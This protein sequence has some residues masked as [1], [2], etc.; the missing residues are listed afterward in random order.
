[1]L[2]WDYVPGLENGLVLE[3]WMVV[4]LGALGAWKPTRL[5]LCLLQ[6]GSIFTLFFSAVVYTVLK[7]PWQAG[8]DHFFFTFMTALEA[9]AVLM[10]FISLAK[11]K[12]DAAEGIAEACLGIVA[13]A[14]ILKTLLDLIVFF[15]ELWAAKRKGKVRWGPPPTT[16]IK[17]P[18][19][20]TT[21]GIGYESVK[22]AQPA[23]SV[24]HS[25]LR[26]NTTGS[27]RPSDVKLARFQTQQQASNSYFPFQQPTS[28]V[29]QSRTRSEG[30]EATSLRSFSS[31]TLS[32]SFDSRRSKLLGPKA[33]E[34]QAEQQKIALI[35]DVRDS[36]L[37]VR[38]KS[39]RRA[40]ELTLL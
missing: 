32:S 39:R 37:H 35:C 25:I 23:A 40:S 19:E 11:H 24:S 2:F 20:M 8:V 15:Y 4:L 21:S 31:P 18:V 16:T 1:M 10:V 13:I 34:K 22:D 9:M 38:R 27:R 29:E 28:P 17:D 5:S 30:V 26:M 6:T 33:A 14:A 36:P 7:K 12:D 3:L